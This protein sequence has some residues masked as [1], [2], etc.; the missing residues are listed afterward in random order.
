MKHYKDNRIEPYKTSHVFEKTTDYY[1][2]S[3]VRS[4]FSKIA[5]SLKIEVSEMCCEQNDICCIDLNEKITNRVD[6]SDF[7]IVTDVFSYPSGNHWEVSL[8]DKIYVKILYTYKENVN[9]ISLYSYEFK[10]LIQEL[11]TKQYIIFQR[12]LGRL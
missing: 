12:L 7:S 3:I 5:S 6:W 9:N 2:P 1:S 4:R 8:I 10:A 11:T